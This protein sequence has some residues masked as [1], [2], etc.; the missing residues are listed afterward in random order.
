MTYSDIACQAYRLWTARH[1]TF[2]GMENRQQTIRE[3]V[4]EN[5]RRIREAAGARQ[6]DVATAARV[7]GL[8][9]TRSKIAALERG[10]KSLD[11]AEVVLLAEAMGEIAG[12]PVGVADLLAGDGAVRLSQSLVIHREALR[13]F[14]GGDSVRV[15]LTDIPGG[16]DAMARAIPRVPERIQRMKLLAGPDMRA[17]DL[18][19]AA[20]VA[21]EA[22]ERVGRTLGV[23]KMDVAYLAVGLWGRTLAEERDRRVGDDVPLASR[24]AKRG[25]VTRRLVE[26]LRVRLEEVSN[27]ER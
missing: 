25:R 1:G 26:D 13:R 22:E 3:V 23:S 11:L 21:G 7:L 20:T 8:R 6:D 27:V 24:S 18:R 5:V 12:Q 17:E 14:L 9:W 19:H 15:L 4:G 16:A 2:S 10:E